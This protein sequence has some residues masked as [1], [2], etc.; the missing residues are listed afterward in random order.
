MVIQSKYSD[1][2]DS[3]MAMGQDKNIYFKRTRELFKYS[4]NKFEKLENITIQLDSN[5]DITRNILFFCG[6]IYLFYTVDFYS[7]PD[8][9]ISFTQPTSFST[10]DY[11]I[12]RKTFFNKE[13]IKDYYKDIKEKKEV[14]KIYNY[15]FKNNRVESLFL[16]PTDSFGKRFSFTD[17]YKLIISNCEELNQPIVIFHNG[18]FIT[19][20]RLSDTGII[21][22]PDFQ[23][24]LLVF[25]R[26]SQYLSNELGYA[27]KEM[28]EIEDKEKIKKHGFNKYSFRKP[29]EKK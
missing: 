8:V 25:Q 6:K 28:I 17:E 21:G 23:N 22:H 7:R 3:G 1:Y 12:K 4:D 9:L 19:N 26:L 13:E 10:N 14:N 29:K 24:P 15:F 27:N 11:L 20:E 2:Y 18:Y 5:I 16:F